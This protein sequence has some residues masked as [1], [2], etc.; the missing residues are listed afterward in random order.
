M[1]LLL[2]IYGLGAGGAERV[3][4]FIA[5]E[6]ASRGHEVHLLT[7]AGGEE[8]FFDP[9]DRVRRIRLNV[10]ANSRSALDGAWA[11]LWRIRAIRHQLRAL[12]PDAVISFT[13]MVNVLAL[14]ACAGMG[15]PV[16]VSERS[17]PRG[18]VVQRRWRILRNVLYRRAHALVVQTNS[19][20]AWFRRRLPAALPIA[21]IANPTVLVANTDEAQLNPP[22]PFILAAGRLAHEKGFDLLI[23]A[24]RIVAREG[25]ELHLVI[26]GAGPE[27]HALQ[28]LV[29]QRGLERRVHFVG[30]VKAI[31]TLMKQAQAFVLSSRFEG[32][33][34]VLL[35]ALASGLPV[36]SVDC[37]SGPREILDDGRYGILVP[38]EDPNALA[39]GI[40]RV[41]TDSGLRTRLSLSGSQRATCYRP[42][43]IITKWEEVIS[44][45]QKDRT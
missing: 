16:V 45:G 27:A 36:V 18:L 31:G 6:L 22:R 42:D 29:A 34:N 33:P 1:K 12:K 23:E 2:M 38:P 37:L 32:F 43:V 26:A 10:A 8:D 13:T 14:A 7:L 35:E 19:S 40:V 5:D 20:A 17:D 9:G 21:V 24:F 25:I 41:A 3:L 44:D 4:T 30:Q 15:M 11:N 39:E 28:L